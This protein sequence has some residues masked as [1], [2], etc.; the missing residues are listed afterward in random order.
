MKISSV[1]LPKV[2]VIIS[3]LVVAVVVYGA[4]IIMKQ[5]LNK[6]KED[7]VEINKGSIQEGART[8]YGRSDTTRR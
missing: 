2:S 1:K 4:F 8:T 6:N 3:V 7:G 5:R